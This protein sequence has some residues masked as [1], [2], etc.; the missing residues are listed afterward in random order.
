MKQ[1]FDARYAMTASA[2][3]LRRALK[4]KLFGDLRSRP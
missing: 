3:A 2:K 4:A 1:R